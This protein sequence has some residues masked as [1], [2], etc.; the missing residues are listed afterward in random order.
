MRN[1]DAGVYYGKNDM[2]WKT[3]GTSDETCVVVYCFME[4]T[5]VKIRRP[6]LTIETITFGVAEKIGVIEPSTATLTVP[7]EKLKEIPLEDG[8]F[9]IEYPDDMKYLREHK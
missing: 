1:K 8:S 5:T 3:T 9:I 4:P 7:N 6:D 2:I